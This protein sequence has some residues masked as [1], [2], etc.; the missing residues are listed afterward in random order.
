M[1][2]N[3]LQCI[4]EEGSGL[5]QCLNNAHLNW[6]VAWTNR[7]L[8][9]SRISQEGSP[10]GP[11]MPSSSQYQSAA[12][13]AALLRTSLPCSREEGSGLL[14]CTHCLFS[15]CYA[16]R[17]AISS[18]ISMRSR[19]S[20]DLLQCLWGLCLGKGCKSQNAPLVVIQS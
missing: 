3:C 2:S 9:S 20:S 17:T 16:A 8:S 13:R 7:K 6:S 18:N 15:N 1:L 12:L 10:C 11:A 19:G 4:G 5:L 14:L